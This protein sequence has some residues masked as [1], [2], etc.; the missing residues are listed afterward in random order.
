MR[1]EKINREELI[2]EFINNPDNEKNNKI[3]FDEVHKDFTMI[4]NKGDINL[5][6]EDLKFIYDFEDAFYKIYPTDS[7][8]DTLDSI[9]NCEFDNMILELTRTTKE[10]WNYYSSNHMRLMLNIFNEKE[11]ALLLSDTRKLM[12]N[13]SFIR[14]L[15][16]LSVDDKMEI[17]SFIKIKIPENLRVQDID[18]NSDL[19]KV[20]NTLSDESKRMVYNYYNVFISNSHKGK[21]ELMGELS[22]NSLVDFSN[23]YTKV[24]D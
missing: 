17:L 12:L 22:N 9:D 21:S 4:K 15:S 10:D 14:T 23:I 3:L 1:K 2:K 7:D 20:Y 18:C 11:R 19:L 16:A 24:C 6:L 5:T 8:E 13:T